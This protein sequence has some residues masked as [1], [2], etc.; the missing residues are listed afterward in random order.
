M[1]ER[2]FIAPSRRLSLPCL[3]SSPSIRPLHKIRLIVLGSLGVGKTQLVSRLLGR[4][5]KT[6]HY[7][8]VNDFHVVTHNIENEIYKLDILDTSGISPYPP[9]METCTLMTG[10]LFL[11]VYSVSD[12]GSWERAKHL[13]DTIEKIKCNAEN[14]KVSFERNFK[15]SVRQKPDLAMES[16]KEPIASIL[17]VGNKHDNSECNVLGR[18]VDVWLKKRQFK[19]P[20]VVSHIEA[21]AKTYYNVEA[22]YDQLLLMANLPL[23]LNFVTT[24][25]RNFRSRRRSNSLL[26]SPFCSRDRAV[27]NSLYLHERNFKSSTRNRQTDLNPT[28][29]QI[30]LIQRPPDLEDE[31]ILAF[32]KACSITEMLKK[33]KSPKLSL[34][35]VSKLLVSKW[36]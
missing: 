14:I 11:V 19:L 1:A 10:D 5:F 26:V 4:A 27:R 22:M 23:E 24:H 32:I 35:T 18:E 31:I 16:T 36:S 8:T 21:S 34:R 3:V 2:R 28:Q 12:P 30:R 25:S 6:N 33:Q 29:T 15:N 20:C 9:A 13:I 7:P 17:V